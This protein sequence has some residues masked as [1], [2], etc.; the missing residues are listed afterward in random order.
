MASLEKA[1]IAARTTVFV[2]GDHGFYRIHSTFQPNVILREMKVLST[3]PQGTITE[4]RAAAHRGAIKLKDPHDRAL[5]A[6]IETRF[7]ELADG[8]YRGLFR[9]VRRQ[10]IAALGGDPD[11]LFIIEPVEGYA[12][13]AAT[14]GSFLQ[15]AARYGDHG[16]LPTEPRMHTG[17]I[18]AGDGIARGAVLPLARQIDIAPTAARLLGIDM[19]DIDGVAM[20]GLL[21]RPVITVG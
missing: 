9:L 12:V 3:D 16:F 15:P 11:A 6:Q 13:S 17:L 14:T 8:K 7:A 21:A 20:V 1:G 18:A 19:A 4:W 5:A 10:E 2:T